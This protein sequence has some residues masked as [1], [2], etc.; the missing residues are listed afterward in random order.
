MVRKIGMRILAAFALFAALCP[1]ATK[2]ETGEINGAQFRIDMPGDWNGSLV[3]YCHGYSPVPVRYDN[4][5]P[6][7]VLNVFLEEGCAVAQSGY[8]AGGW[9][10]EE[11]VHDT[12]ALR[13][14]FSSKYGVPKETYVTGHSMGGFLTMLLMERFA[15]DYDAGLALCGPLGPAHWFMMRRVFDMRVVFDYYFPGALPSPVHVPAGYAMSPARNEEIQRLLD[16]KPAQSEAMRRYSGIHTNKELAATIVFWTYILKDLQQRGGGNPFDNRNTIYDGTPDDNAVNDGVARYAADPR[17]AEYLLRY[18]TPTGRLTRPLLAIHTTYDP[19]VP[20]WVTDAYQTIAEEGG[21]AGLFVQQYVK[22][23][24]HC[25]ILPAE[26]RRG[27]DQLRE[28]KAT[29]KRPPA[30]WNH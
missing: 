27:F 15:N 14:Y 21:G 7:P 1:A 29:G 20:P 10:I 12:A 28:W 2:T 23:D 26:V 16:S 11:A 30:G 18:Y 8:A 6:N 24:G 13:R 9:A 5:K 22:R 4:P 25:A 3:V 17:A 19:L